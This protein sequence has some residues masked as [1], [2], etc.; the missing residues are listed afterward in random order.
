[1]KQPEQFQIQ[2]RLDIIHP[3]FGEWIETVEK[4]YDKEGNERWIEHPAGRNVDVVAIPI[5]KDDQIKL[6]A[7]VS[8][9]GFPLGLSSTGWPI[10]KTGHIASDP[11]VDVDGRRGF[12]IDATTRE[13]MSGSPVILRI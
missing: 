9:I 1:M 6:F 8:I 2:S 11:L 7:L 3:I 5:T 10:W 12:L 4:L 13:G